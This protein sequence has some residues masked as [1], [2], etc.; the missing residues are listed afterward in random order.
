MFYYKSGYG[1][2]DKLYS[3][4]TGPTPFI[5]KTRTD[6]YTLKKIENGQL[7]NCVHTR[8]MQRFLH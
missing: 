1:I 7:V 5:E 8:F 4:W 6:T 3:L 2:K